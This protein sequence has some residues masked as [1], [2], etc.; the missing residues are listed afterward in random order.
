LADACELDRDRLGDVED[1]PGRT[2]GRAYP[3]NFARLEIPHISRERRPFLAGEQGGVGPT[4]THY[5]PPIDPAAPVETA[6][7]V[8]GADAPFAEETQIDLLPVVAGSR[9]P[10]F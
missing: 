5:E 8:R 7:T 3:P 6:A 4:P 9:T 2:I 1:R 10:P